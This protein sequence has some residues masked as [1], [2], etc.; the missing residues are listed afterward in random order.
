MTEQELKPCPFCGNEPTIVI[1][2]GK[3]GWRDR[4]SVLCDYEHGGCGAE[5]GWYH[6]EAEAIASWN[7]RV[8]PT[9]KDI[10]EYIE[11]THKENME[12]VAKLK[13]KY[14]VAK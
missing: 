10:E 12:M 9:L 13:R 6:Y 11:K 2:K 14:E 8:P 4:Y 1:R 7:K 5:S 3:D